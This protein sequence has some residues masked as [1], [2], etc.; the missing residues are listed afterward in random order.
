MELWPLL[1][2]AGW[3]FALAGLLHFRGGS[4]HAVMALLLEG[5]VILAWQIYRM[6]PEGPIDFA[7]KMDGIGLNMA[8]VLALAVIVA[9]VFRPCRRHD[10][11]AKLLW[12]SLLFIDCYSLLIERIGC[13]LFGNDL[14]WALLRENWAQDTA[15]GVCERLFSPAFVWVPLS[16]QI[17]V[18]TCIVGA[19]LWT[20]KPDRGRP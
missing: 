2:L 20:L 11:L 3:C 6:A 17:F 9:F 14:P 4:G 18:S 1:G 7:F 10:L 19:Y 5:K 13:N 15:A 16:V 12:L 8:Y